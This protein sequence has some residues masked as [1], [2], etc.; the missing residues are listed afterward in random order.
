MGVFDDITSGLGNKE[1]IGLGLLGTYTGGAAAGWLGTAAGAGIGEKQD[2]DIA[3]DKAARDAWYDDFANEHGGDAQRE[4]RIADMSIG[5]AEAQK[6][7]GLSRGELGAMSKGS[8]QQTAMRARQGLT[9]EERAEVRAGYGTAKRQ[10]AASLGQAGVRGPAAVSAQKQLSREASFDE[11]RLASSMR[12]SSERDFESDVGKRQLG[13]EATRFGQAQL[14]LGEQQTN[15]QLAMANAPEVLAKEGVLGSTFGALTVIC[16]ELHRQGYISGEIY[17]ADQQYADSVDRDI[18]NGYYLW[19]KH[20]AKGMRTSK[21]LTYIVKPIAI[22]WATETA[23][24]LGKSPHG[25]KFGKLFKNLGE[26]MCG[27]IGKGL[28]LWQRE[29]RVLN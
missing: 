20:V 11:A 8:L 29:K 22:A 13:T 19:A 18:Y 17:E 16:T 7:Y 5:E 25:S 2:R 15:A 27:L 21:L 6:M 10:T 26:P 1:S 24:R 14:G 4:R 12:R 9:G 23:F 28:R 3:E